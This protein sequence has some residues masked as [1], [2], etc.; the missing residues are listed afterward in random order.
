MNELIAFNIEVIDV[1]AQ[2]FFGSAILPQLTV[3]AVILDNLEEPAG[4]LHKA[5]MDFF[6]YMEDAMII[7]PGE[8][9]LVDDFAAFVLKMM[10]YDEGRRVI[11]LRKEMGF[12]MC[13]QRVDAKTDVCVMER[14]GTGAKY[15]LLV[16]EDKVRKLYLC[17]SKIRLPITRAKRHLSRDD[18]E[19]QLIAEAMAAFYENN[20]ARR[21]AGLPK[22]QSRTFAG[23]TMV[24]TAPTFYKIPVTD[25]ILIS[26]AT[27]QYPPKITTIEKLVPPVPF[28]ERLANDGM[29]PLVNRH[30]ILQCFEA[31]RQFLVSYSVY[32][33]K[34]NI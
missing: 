1:N 8:E 20:R 23:I 12:E 27:A 9:S 28:P 2:T 11:H 17:V 3:S 13:G 18:P 22:L 24:G 19:P 31:F 21:A 16:Q 14:S 30:I 32:L 10:R 5:D 25:E 15:L 6:A 29:K 7:P 34:S 4:P 33:G 26:L